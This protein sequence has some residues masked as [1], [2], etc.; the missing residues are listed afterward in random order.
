MT[1]KI[2]GDDRID[3]GGLFQFLG[4]GP[5][6][7]ETSLAYESLTFPHYQDTRRSETK[8]RTT[9]SRRSR[10]TEFWQVASVKSFD[11][12]HF[13]TNTVVVK[14][15]KRN[16]SVRR[17]SCVRCCLS[18]A[19]VKEGPMLVLFWKTNSFVGRLVSE[20]CLNLNFRIFTGLR[21]SVKCIR[22]RSTN[23]QD[24]ALVSSPAC[25]ISNRQHH[26][27]CVGSSF[28][29]AYRQEGRRSSGL[30]VI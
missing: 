17:L 30:L 8:F 1:T 7:T 4:P 3:A 26:S 6:R 18:L 5:Y 28:S 29:P 2:R 21:P 25:C 14:E 16:Y 19:N 9:L 20:S 11:V 10:D 15:R 13:Q 12:K 27:F 22:P 24:V 23:V